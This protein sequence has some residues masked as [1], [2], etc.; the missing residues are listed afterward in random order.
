MIAAVKGFQRRH[1]LRVD[2]V[3]NPD[4]PTL[5]RL[6]EILTAQR[7]KIP[8][9]ISKP[10]S[11]RPVSALPSSSNE[12]QHIHWPDSAPLG[13]VESPPSETLPAPRRPNEVIRTAAAGAA[14]PAIAGQLPSILGAIAG[15]L[16]LTLP[17][18]R[19]APKE[20]ERERQCDEQLE[21]D[22]EKCRQVRAK[23]GPQAAQRCWASANLRYGNCLAGKPVPDLDEGTD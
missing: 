16:G 12:R 9:Q 18:G 11:I 14:I 17:L 15:M 5:N 8:D 2:G 19:D 22:S 3:M 13:A 23:H 21:L 1:G 20:D 10:E 6:N 4:G 7:A